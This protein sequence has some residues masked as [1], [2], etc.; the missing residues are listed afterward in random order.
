M[1][2]S[3]LVLIVRAW[4]GVNAVL[5]CY[6]FLKKPAAASVVGT[7]I[8]CLIEFVAWFV[9]SCWIPIMFRSVYYVQQRGST[10]SGSSVMA[11]RRMRYKKVDKEKLCSYHN[12]NPL[13]VSYYWGSID[14]FVAVSVRQLINSKCALVF[15]YLL[16]YPFG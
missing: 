14:G 4:Q 1:I 8:L 9:A 13:A 3:L 6:F 5:L 12:F 7:P 10:A 15:V 16:L 2:H 11:A